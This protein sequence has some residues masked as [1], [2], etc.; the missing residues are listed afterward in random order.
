MELKRDDIIKALECCPEQEY[1]GDCPYDIECM[2]MEFL[3]LD[4]LSLIK[5]LTEENERV[6]LE[7]AGFEAGAKHAVSFVKADT[8]RKMQER[9]EE[10]YTD[11]LITDDM[12]V[13]I[14][15]IKQ[16]IKDIA[17]EMLCEM[18]DTKTEVRCTDCKHFVGCERV[19]HG[20]CDSYEVA[21]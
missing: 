7:Y 11:K 21:R 1:C 16:N 6:K 2:G 19:C 12:T 20:I 5:E 10:L 3:I 14:G 15:V 9:L 8:V 17:K 4:A 13:S 18:G